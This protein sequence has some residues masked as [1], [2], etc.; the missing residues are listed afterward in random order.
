MVSRATAPIEGSASPRNPSVRM[1]SR[2]SSGSL[3]VAWRSTAS[4]RSSRLMPLPSSVT[5][6]ARRPPP[7]VSTSMWVA[8]AS[9]AFSTSSLTTLAGR[10]TTSPAAMRLT[11]PS[12][13]WRTGISRAWVESDGGGGRVY[14]VP[15]ANSEWRVA[16]RE[17]RLFL[18]AIRSFQSRFA[19]SQS[20]DPGTP[21]LRF[22][23]AL[24]RGLGR[25]GRPARERAHGGAADQ[26]DQPVE[27]VLAVGL[28]GAVALR[29]DHQHALA[30]EPS[31]GE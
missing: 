26:L 4:A 16:N 25:P 5:Q 13:S 3:E 29:V 14:S 27:R 20:L 28:L 30:G 2:S 23:A 8:P 22:D 31:T 19:L 15:G 17:P 7:S 10:S 6:I 24:A 1:S 9:S 11:M 18:F 12:D 21:L